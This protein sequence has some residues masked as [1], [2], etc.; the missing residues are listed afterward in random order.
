MSNTEVC[1]SI[2]TLSQQL[3]GGENIEVT[4]DIL[5][6]PPHTKFSKRWKIGEE[7]AYMLNGFVIMHHEDRPDEFYKKGDVGRVPLPHVYE[8]VYKMS[9][10]EEGATILVFSVQE[11][12]QSG[13]AI[14][15]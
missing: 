2:Q 3:E 12:G 4:V 14:V 8:K 9:T 11:P 6:I 13:W 5:S 15:K 10:Q 7:F 1:L